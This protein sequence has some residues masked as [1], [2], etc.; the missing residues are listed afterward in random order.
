[1]DFGLK[2]RTAIV[3]G[4]S[5]GIGRAIAQVLAQEGV[6]VALTARDGSRLDEGVREIAG[7]HGVEAVAV[8]ADLSLPE[9][10][11]LVVD[12]AMA[13]FG[14]LDILVNC[15]G[16]TK[17]GDFFDLTDED[18]SDGFALKFFGYVR[19]TRAAWPHLKARRGAIINIIGVAS[20]TP[21]GDHAI[22]G[23]VNSALLNFGKAMADIGRRDGVRVNSINPGYIQTDRL[24]DRLKSVA[25]KT[26]S[27][28]E[29]VGRDILAGIGVRRFGEPMEIG[30]ITAFLASDLS[31]Y[32]EGASLDVDGGW[33]RGI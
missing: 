17:R 18:W 9:A 26:G 21:T 3:T 12:A 19:M 15:A 8:A 33:T 31:A 6:R 16:A 22:A 25:A 32:I 28:P 2:G 29:I 5:R 4:A 7:R 10:P 24:M 27:T 23:S 13:A 1:M 20:R 30:R 14:Q 11:A